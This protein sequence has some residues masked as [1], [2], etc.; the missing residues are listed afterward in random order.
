M[1]RTWTARIR[2]DRQPVHCAA[3]VAEAS[4]APVCGTVQM[5]NLADRD[6]PINQRTRSDRWIDWEEQVTCSSHRVTANDVAGRHVNTSWL[7]LTLIDTVVAVA[8][9]VAADVVAV[10]FV[11]L[12]WNE[13]SGEVVEAVAFDWMQDFALGTARSSTVL[14]ALA[15]EVWH[16][17]LRPIVDHGEVEVAELPHIH[18][19]HRMRK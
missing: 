7:R 9:D 6:W 17:E 19:E 3:A 1:C 14:A 18:N 4:D 13:K 10:A 12:M 5:R 11:L 15:I 8:A 16:F 2:L